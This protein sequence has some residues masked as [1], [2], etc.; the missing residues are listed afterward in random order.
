MT[1]P[2]DCHVCNPHGASIIRVATSCPEH[3]MPVGVG[4]ICRCVACCCPPGQGHNHPDFEWWCHY[5]DGIRDGQTD[6]QARFSADVAD[7]RRCSPFGVT[8]SIPHVG[9]IMR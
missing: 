6:L 5:R 7:G 3:G 1:E 9:C 2:A 8:H 4:G